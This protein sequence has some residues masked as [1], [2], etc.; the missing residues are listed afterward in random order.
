VDER[1]YRFLKW[2]AVLMAAAWI[3]WSLYESLSPTTESGNAPYLAGNRMFEDGRYERA[4][5]EYE[6][7]LLDAPDHVHAQRGKAR[8]LM[9]LGRF[10]D[11]LEAFDMAIAMDPAFAGTYA[12][13]G[14][15]Y[16]RMGRYEAAATDYEHALQL[17]PE[18]AKGPNW[19]TRFLRLQPEKPPT[20]DDRARY[21]RQQLAKPPME[22]QLTMPEIDA[23]QRPYRQ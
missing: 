7:A 15:L 5:R 11:A 23:E 8:T 21:I 18:L 1:L 13:R 4:V 12:N 17:D 6:A 22:R 3:G 19:L 2:T 16:D 9:Q 14:I 10:Q 20:I